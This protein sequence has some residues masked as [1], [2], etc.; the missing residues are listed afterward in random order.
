MYNV[1]LTPSDALRSSRSESSRRPSEQ[2]SLRSTPSRSQRFSFSPRS[3]AWP[4]T[5]PERLQLLEVAV[6]VEDEV[7][8]SAPLCA[9]DVDVSRCAQRHD[10]V[11]RSSLPGA[12]VDGGEQRTRRAGGIERQKT[13]SV[14]RRS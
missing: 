8:G 5:R 2:S 7:N 1:E 11:V 6:D 12:V 10:R 14:R 13:R 3:L 9:I 4:A